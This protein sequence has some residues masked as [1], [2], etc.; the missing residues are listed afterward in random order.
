ME[1]S[2]Y[3]EANRFSASKE[4]P[5]ILWNPKVQSR[6]H[7]SPPPD[8]NLSQIDPHIPFPEDPS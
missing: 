8:P 2:P 5:R 3:W 1:H 4:I 7:N 6:I